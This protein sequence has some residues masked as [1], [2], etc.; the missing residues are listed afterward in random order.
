MRNYLFLL[1]F[2]SVLL[3]VSSC[4]EDLDATADYQEIPVVYGLLNFS[5]AAHY[6]RVQKGFLLEG[7]ALVAAQQPDSI[8]FRDSI[9][10]SLRYLPNGP[11]NVCTLID[12][13]TIGLPKQE[14]S[15]AN[16]PNLLYRSNILL[17]PNKTYQLKVKNMSSGKEYIA[18]TLLIEDFQPIN[19]QRGQRFNLVPLSSTPRV[20]WVTAKNA[21]AYDVNCRFYYKETNFLSGEMR[22]TFCDIPLVKR[23]GTTGINGGTEMD[24]TINLTNFYN[25]MLSQIPVNPDVNREFNIRK[26][27]HFQFSLGGQELN[28]FINSQ[29]AQSG[30]TSNEAVPPYT[31]FTGGAQGIFSSRYF[32]TIDS[33]LLSGESLDDISCNPLTRPLRFKNSAG[34]VCF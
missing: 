21:A 18:S 5:D 14:G 27:L 1:S 22:D 23:K 2:C 7:N 28:S 29:L 6:I 19:I 33:V 10:V 17:D 13:N 25:S 32:K 30:F 3:F 20:I 26:G 4:K 16:V 24:A 34:Q 11:E 15:F 8:Y 12:G 31:N 9:R